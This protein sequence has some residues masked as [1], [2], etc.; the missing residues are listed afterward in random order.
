MSLGDFLKVC[1]TF[2]NFQTSDQYP[3]ESVAFNTT[4]YH[5]VLMWLQE[6]WKMSKMRNKTAYIFFDLF[7]STVTAIDNCLENICNGILSWP[8]G[9]K[10]TRTG[11]PHRCLRGNAAKLFRSY[12]SEYFWATTPAKW[13]LNKVNQ[14]SPLLCFIEKPTICF[15]LQNKWLVST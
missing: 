6:I 3:Y 13:L 11:L 15:A 2:R 12:F 7:I 9:S 4:V 5:S 1:T 8:R 14:F 10:L